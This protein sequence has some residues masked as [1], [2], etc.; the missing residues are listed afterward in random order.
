MRAR[1]VTDIVSAMRRNIF[2]ALAF[3]LA[4]AGCAREQKTDEHA[5]H[6]TTTS[7]T[8]APQSAAA[9][10]AS[11]AAPPAGTS[12][13]FGEASGYLSA[14][15]GTGKKPG[16]IVIQ[17]WWGV[18]NWIRE[19]TDRFA[20]QGYVAV[21]PDLYRGK[22]TSDP[23]E[24]HELMR[25]MPEDRAMSDLKAAFNYLAS[26]PDVDPERIGVIGW[27][28]G[29]GYALALAT[30]EPRLAA[31]AINYGRLVTDFD[32][33][34]KI[35]SM[36]LGNFGGKDRGIPADDVKKFG[37]TLTK[38]GKLGDIKIYDDAG[39]GFMNP[40]NKDGYDAEAAQDA[41]GRIDRFFERTLRAKIN[42]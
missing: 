29:G 34:A 20:K 40:N 31:T 18:D 38:A 15:T 35:D 19:Q 21:A 27:C 9:D 1:T 24:A 23:G 10:T 11:T 26:R 42:S 2:F 13:T 30:Q 28:M 4:I 14:P 17:E 36:I 3:T 8:T 33:I 16:L 6:T 12:V 7:A 22:S 32:T 25:G 39:H 5:S 41:W 37:A